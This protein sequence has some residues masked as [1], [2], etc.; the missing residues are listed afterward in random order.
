[1]IRITPAHHAQPMRNIYPQNDILFYVDLI[2][3]DVH[4]LAMRRFK[5]GLGNS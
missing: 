3:R 1:M 5:N 4:K 2:A